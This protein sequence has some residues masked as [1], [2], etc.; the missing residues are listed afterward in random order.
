M[1]QLLNIL[2][3]FGIPEC[4]CLVYINKFSENK[5]FLFVWY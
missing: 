4:V 2:N 3:V 5:V 1:V